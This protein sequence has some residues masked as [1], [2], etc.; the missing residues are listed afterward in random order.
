MRRATLPIPLTGAAAWRAG[1]SPAAL[2]WLAALVLSGVELA[3][4]DWPQWRGPSSQGLSSGANLPTTWS[5]SENLAWKAPLAGLG[6][7]SPIVWGDRVIVTSQVAARQWPPDLHPR[8]ARDD[9]SLADREQP[10]GGGVLSRSAADRARP[11]PSWWR[12]SG[13]MVSGCGLTAATG[14]FSELHEKHNLATP[15][16]LTDGERIYAWFGNGL[17]V[18]LDMDGGSSGSGISAWSTR[19][20]RRAGATAARPPCTGFVILLCDHP[21]QSYL[22]ALDRARARNAGWQTAGADACRTAR[23]W[24]SRDRTATNCSSTRPSA[25]TRT[26]PRQGSCCGTPGANGRRRYRRP[27]STMG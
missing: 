14:P 13:G 11:R 18:A 22:L 21:R 2:V 15:T 8:L 1:H 26:N 10:I 7:S 20:S 3:A 25:S 23:P 16:P 4:G 12:R 17:I 27:S 5:A 9:R 6:A 19:R 24:S